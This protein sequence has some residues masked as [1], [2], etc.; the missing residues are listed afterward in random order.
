MP[1]RERIARL[2]LPRFSLARLAVAFGLLVVAI[3]L[4]IAGFIG[5]VSALHL[6]LLRHLS[7]PVAE[8]LIGLTLLL[9]A[10]AL[11]LI[12]RR[13]TRPL[14]WPKRSTSEGSDATAQAIAWVQQH[15]GQSAVLAAVLGF[16]MGALPEARKAMS[17]L[18]KTER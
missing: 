13:L 15:P 4:A 8:L 11:C 5:L 3:G 10:L 12:A 2:G 18:T 7:P 16:C 9:L 6:Y 1:L 14:P 17:D